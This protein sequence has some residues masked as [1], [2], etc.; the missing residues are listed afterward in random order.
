MQNCRTNILVPSF[1]IEGFLHSANLPEKEK[2]QLVKKYAELL[3]SKGF[4]EEAQLKFLVED[5]LIKYGILELH[6]AA[7]AEAA[8]SYRKGTTSTLLIG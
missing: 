4:V 6:A 1:T 3:K 5:R 2:E 8:Q 7:I